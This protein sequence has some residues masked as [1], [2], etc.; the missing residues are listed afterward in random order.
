MQSGKEI[1][2]IK[3]AEAHER[4]SALSEATVEGVQNS[5]ELPKR[6]AVT[7]VNEWVRELRHRKAEEAT[8][9]FE[10]LF[11]EAA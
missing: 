11:Q 2:V 9:R 1:K 6:D 3:R 7:V 5:G 10:S 4:H 8:R